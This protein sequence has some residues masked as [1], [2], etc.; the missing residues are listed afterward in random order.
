MTFASYASV[1]VAIEQAKGIIIARQGCS[2]E[3]AFE[4][5][6]S[7]SQRTHVK[8]H[9]VAADLVEQA[10]HRAAAACQPGA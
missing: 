5:L 4:L 6:V 3:D 10:R 2:A 8:L 9:D 1:A 7:M